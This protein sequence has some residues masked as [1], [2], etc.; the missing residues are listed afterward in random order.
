MNNGYASDFFQ[1]NRG[2]SQ[3]CP[4]SRLLLLLATEVLARSIRRDENISA[5]QINDTESKLSLY[6]DD[7]TAFISDVDSANQLFNLLNDFNACSGL[8]IYTTKTERMWLGSL[9]CQKLKENILPL[10][11]LGQKSTVYVIALGV[12][13]AYDPAVSNK[14]NFTDKLFALK[15]S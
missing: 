10:I 14:I 6:A 8:K 12:A 1:L 5:L 3:G 4:L 7:I 2:V 11:Y 15:K 13:F 9:K